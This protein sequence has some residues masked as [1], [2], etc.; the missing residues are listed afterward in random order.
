MA[1]KKIGQPKPFTPEEIEETAAGFLKITISMDAICLEQ[2]KDH[3]DESQ[4]A[5]IWARYRVLLTEAIEH[6]LLPTIA[7]MSHV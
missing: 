4:A 1:K 3:G 6:G 5:Q 2:C 7:P